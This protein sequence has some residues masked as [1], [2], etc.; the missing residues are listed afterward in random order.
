[1]HVVSL[2]PDD[3]ERRTFS[4]E[5]RGYDR[6]EVRKFLFEVAAS[7]RLALS[8]TTPPITE[9]GPATTERLT[10]P[11]TDDTGTEG[12]ARLVPPPTTSVDLE[13]LG[14][15]VAELLR[16]A[17]N[18]VTTCHDRAA[19]EAAAIREEAEHDAEEIR[20]R[21]EGDVLWHHEQAKRVLITAQEQADAIVADAEA[22]G[23][24]VLASAKEQAKRH[25]RQVTMQLRQHAEHILR[26]ERDTLRRLH[27][28]HTDIAAAIDTLTTGDHRPVVDLTD[29]P[30]QLQVSQEADGLDVDAAADASAAAADPV[31]RMVRSA[32]VRA[33]E[34]ASESG[35]VDPPTAAAVGRT[36]SGRVDTSTKAAL[37]SDGSGP[38]GPTSDGSA[39]RG[40]TVHAINGGRGPGRTP[41]PADR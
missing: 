11:F 29:L 38:S 8:T 19:D 17:Q 41:G 31:V 34:H 40:A 1:L 32:V 35:P 7:L 14:G 12:E 30:P 23:R 6:D 39:G 25:A 37:G 20:R 3:I 16:A 24:A 9:P 28:A 13:R 18:I 22:Q 27:E 10:V 33:A 15:E 21:A 2:T 26:A 5:T 36:T 4:I